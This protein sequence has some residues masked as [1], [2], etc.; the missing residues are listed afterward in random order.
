MV[1]SD[2]IFLF[3]FVKSSY[4]GDLCNFFAYFTVIKKSCQPGL[5]RA[6]SFTMSIQV[7]SRN[8]GSLQNHVHE[9]WS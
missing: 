8:T 3:F 6:D 5:L 7:Y 4:Q 2:N 1:F 9:I